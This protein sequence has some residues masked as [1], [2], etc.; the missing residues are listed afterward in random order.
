M[1]PPPPPP[2]NVLRPAPITGV[3]PSGSDH[4]EDWMED[5]EPHDADSDLGSDLGEVDEPPD[6]EWDDEEEDDL[7]IGAEE[8]AQ[9]LEQWHQ[10]SL[11]VE[12]H[13]RSAHNDFFNHLHH[14][15]P[16]NP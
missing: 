15:Q 1:K 10:E 6:T 4:E 2:E 8:A 11:A 13:A 3:A 9:I 12:N 5:L 16:S 14:T 7:E